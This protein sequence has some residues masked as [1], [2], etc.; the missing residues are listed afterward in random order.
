MSQISNAQKI[1]FSTAFATDKI[2]GIY[3]GSFATASYDINLDGGTL[4]AKKFAHNFG[5][6]LFCDGIFSYDNV[7]F[8]TS[9]NQGNFT[10]SGNPNPFI[11][12]S[13]SQYFYVFFLS[14]TL[15]ETIYYKIVLT[16][17]D[18]YDNS[19]PSITPVLASSSQFNTYFNSNYNY[20]KLL[21][22][23]NILL[24]NPG[25]GSIGTATIPHNLGY[26]PN[27]KLNYNSLPGQMWQP[28]NG[29]VFDIFL[30]DPSHQYELY[31]YADTQNIYLKYSGGA[32]S[33][34]TFTVYY[35]IYYDV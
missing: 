20:Q 32:A 13:D 35:R 21:I 19:N 6:P 27:Y 33:A 26:I 15:T 5:R 17:I 31:D 2:C 29:G 4:Y 30:Y 22:Q 11:V 3:N 24:N 34:A 25:V 7:N 10:G 16:W 1:A 8:I 18:N 28:I 9:G 23:G 12:Y 14:T